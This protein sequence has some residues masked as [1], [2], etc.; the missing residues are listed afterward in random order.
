MM[1]L[2]ELKN[3]MVITSQA[4]IHHEVP[5]TSSSFSFYD[6]VRR[7]ALRGML[8]LF[9]TQNAHAKFTENPNQKLFWLRYVLIYKRVL[10]IKRIHI[11]SLGSSASSLA[12]SS[13]N[14]SLRELFNNTGQTSS[15]I[16]IQKT[17]C[18]DNHKLPRRNIGVTL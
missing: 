2:N 11:S 8:S 17:T 15:S 3:R 9:R 12:Q 13:S 4:R 1:F 5:R 6:V 10:C 18:T 7:K 14:F 16:T